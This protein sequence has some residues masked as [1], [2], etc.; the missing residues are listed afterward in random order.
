MKKLLERIQDLETTLQ[1]NKGLVQD[2]M[3]ALATL[4][5]QLNSSKSNDHGEDE[6]SKASEEP[7]KDNRAANTDGKGGNKGTEQ[8]L[9]E[10][11][12]FIY[13]KLSDENDYLK[14][15]L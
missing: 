2:S 3:T 10:N 6:T 15:R 14:K 12:E 11:V 1:I 9:K 4:Q 7:S 5:L 8:L 13:R